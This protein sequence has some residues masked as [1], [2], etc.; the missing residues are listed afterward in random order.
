MRRYAEGT[1][2]AVSKSRGEVDKLLR[3]W[4]ADAIQWSDEFK[5]A[6]ATL[7]FIWT[8]DENEY[9]ARFTIKLPAEEELKKGAVDGR[10]GRVSQTKMETLLRTRGRQEH[11]ILLLWLKAALNAVDCGIVSA[12]AIF[13]PFMEGKD[14]RT[15][16][17]IAVPK[18][19]QLLTGSA[20]RLLGTGE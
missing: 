19:A 6:T 5:A 4:G 16:A 1:S 15:V 20:S 9:L 3:E 12:E 10:T 2:V 17:E 13:L 14:G 7:R 11:R 8:Y 18:M